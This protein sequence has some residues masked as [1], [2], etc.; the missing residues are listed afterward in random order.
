M[1]KQKLKTT[2]KEKKRGGTS[3]ISQVSD[4]PVRVNKPR[5]RLNT[6]LSKN[7]TDQVISKKKSGVD[8]EPDY[9]ASRAE[10]PKRLSFK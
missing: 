9:N 2:E 7:I 3:T 1:L 8:Y 6:G 10:E 5:E 4:A